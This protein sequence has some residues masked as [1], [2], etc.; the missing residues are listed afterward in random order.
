MV[1]V[2]TAH[3]IL[4]CFSGP[5]QKHFHDGFGSDAAWLTKQEGLLILAGRLLLARFKHL[6]SEKVTVSPHSHEITAACQKRISKHF[7]HC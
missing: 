1:G 2:L 7:T 5:G 4:H 3:V 6:N